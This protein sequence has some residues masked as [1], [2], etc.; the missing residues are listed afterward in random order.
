MI[1]HIKLSFSLGKSL[2]TPP[3]PRWWNEAPFLIISIF[4]PHG[5]TFISPHLKIIQLSDKRLL[6]I[7]GFV[8]AENN[9]ELNRIWCLQRKQW[10]RNFTA[11]M[12]FRLIKMQMCVGKYFHLLQRHTY[13]GSGTKAT[14]FA[15]PRSRRG[16]RALWTTAE[17]EH[18]FDESH[19][20]DGFWWTE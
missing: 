12:S 19:L 10:K 4:R 5:A 16:L 2:R 15:R 11:I 18:K 7:V 13:E 9:A 3:S 14:P 8:H 1:R 17:S 6:P 20:H